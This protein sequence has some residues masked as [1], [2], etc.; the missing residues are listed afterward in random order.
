VRGHTSS[1]EVIRLLVLT[2]FAAHWVLERL[3]GGVRSRRRF[4]R[5]L[6]RGGETL[7]VLAAPGLR[8]D[9]S[10]LSAE[11]RGPDWGKTGVDASVAIAVGALGA[12]APSPRYS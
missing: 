6:D 5:R 1:S 10:G 7:T 4:I 2:I 9:S 3:Y 11:L 12:W 8:V